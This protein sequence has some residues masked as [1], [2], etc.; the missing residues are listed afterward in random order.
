VPGTVIELVPKSNYSFDGYFLKVAFREETT[1]RRFEFISS[2]SSYPPAY[3]EDERIT[4]FYD[5][6]NPEDSRIGDCRNLFI[7][8]TT[9]FPPGAFFFVFGF[10]LIRTRR[11]IIRQKEM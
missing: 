2:E 4:V 6:E 9:L 3:N 7:V 1:K 11:K 5:P 8:P 10:L